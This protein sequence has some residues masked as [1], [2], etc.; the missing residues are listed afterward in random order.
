MA[1][2]PKFRLPSV[3][4]DHRW[5][6]SAWLSTCILLKQYEQCIRRYQLKPQNTVL[7]SKPVWT[8]GSIHVSR[9]VWEGWQSPNRQVAGWRAGFPFPSTNVS[10]CPML[11]RNNN[12]QLALFKI[13][14]KKSMFWGFHPATVPSG[15]WPPARWCVVPG[16]LLPAPSPGPPLWHKLQ[17]AVTDPASVGVSI[18]DS[19][20]I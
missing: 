2:N 1:L 17:L 7:F 12:T 19:G 13:R 9:N 14:R 20:Q 3:H 15:Q 18:S 5:V 8:R 16:K 4:W 10:C 11:K 6:L